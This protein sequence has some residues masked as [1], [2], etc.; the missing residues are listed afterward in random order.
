MQ[1]CQLI[2]AV[3]GRL[4]DEIL[5]FWRYVPAYAKGS[6]CHEKV[7]ISSVVNFPLFHWDE[8]TSAPASEH[9]PFTSSA[10]KSW[11]FLILIPFWLWVRIPNDF[12]GR[13]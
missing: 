13:L 9:Q 11:T 4:T 1:R 3:G 12:K 10:R 8:E 6:G 2:F 5:F 7:M